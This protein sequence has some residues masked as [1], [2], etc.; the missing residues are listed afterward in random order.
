MKTLIAIVAVI[1]F[2]VFMWF[3]GAGYQPQVEAAG[4]TD[5]DMGTYTFFH[6]PKDETGYNFDATKDGKRVEGVV[7]RSHMFWGSYQVRTL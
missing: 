7:C 1:A 4:Y 5:V 6:C 2:F 3:P